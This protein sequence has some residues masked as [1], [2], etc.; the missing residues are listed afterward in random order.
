MENELNRLHKTKRI[1]QTFSSNLIWLYFT[2]S[3]LTMRKSA[4]KE[5]SQVQTIQ[6][7]VISRYVTQD[8]DN[9]NNF[10][11][12]RRWFCR[13]CLRTACDFLQPESRKSLFE[14]LL[15]CPSI[16]TQTSPN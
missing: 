15:L 16:Q 4:K 9:T 7:I 12:G 14:K 11:I 6:R 1:Y 2:S 5:Q 3:A 13:Q 10:W 8:N